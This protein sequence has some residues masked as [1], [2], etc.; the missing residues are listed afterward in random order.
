MA[1]FG[2][3]YVP[4]KGFIAFT[5]DLSSGAWHAVV[6]PKKLDPAAERW[7]A[8]ALMDLPR[9]VYWKLRASSAIE[10][11]RAA[12]GVG[13]A[14]VLEALDG[15]WD[16][17]QRRLNHRIGDAE[18]DSK[19][20]H[21]E[22]AK[23]LRGQLLS[24]NGTAQTNI[25]YDEEIDF[26]WNQVELASKGATAEY[27]KLLGLGDLLHEINAATND[28]AKGLGRTPGQKRTAPRFAR[29]R[30]ALAECAGV[31]NGVHDDIAWAVAHSEPGPEQDQLKAL[32]Q[33]FEGLLERY[34]APVKG[35]PTGSPGG[36]E[37][38]PGGGND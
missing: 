20:T 7:H 35:E 33:P 6:I 25:S 10:W 3:G 22:A 37:T 38:S 2:Y 28:L 31:F 8:T 30:A 9:V 11:L 21:R 16:R 23:R 1:Q 13:T 14:E 17:L 34:P 26:G 19:A 32:L 24:G 4:E 12:L 5:R 36:G 15:N 18:E 27:V 29:V